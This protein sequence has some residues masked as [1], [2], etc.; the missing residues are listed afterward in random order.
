M[1]LFL[2]VFLFTP[3][4]AIAD[5]AIEKEIQQ[6]ALLPGDAEFLAAREALRTG[7][8]AQLDQAAAHLKQ[9]PL[10]PYVAYYQMLLRLEN[11]DTGT[12]RAFLARPDETPAIDQLRGEWLKILGKRGQ[13]SLFSEE[14][15]QL[16]SEDTE[17]SCYAMQ[18]RLHAHDN[19]A[20]LDAR[21]LWLV[22][23]E[24]QPENCDDVFSKAITEEVIT[25]TDIESRIQLALEAGNTTLASQLSSKLPAKDAISAATLTSIKNN[26][27]RYLKS[28]R[29]KN[30]SKA[31]LTAA[32]FA[33]QR[34]AK[35]LPQ[36]ALNH[37][38]KISDQFSEDKQR[39]FYSWLGY[40][41][42]LMHDARALEW[43]QMAGDA[44]LTEQQHAWKARAAL[45]AQDWSKLLAAIDNMS[46]Q[47]LQQHGAW[48]YWRAR[49]L[50]E[51]GQKEMA[52]RQFAMLSVEHNYYGLLASEEVTTISAANPMLQSYKPTPEEIDEMEANPAIQRALAMF[53]MGLRTEATREWAWAER[54][55]D[56]RQLLVAAEIARRNEIYDRAINTADQTIYLH[57]FNLRY[58]APYRDELREYIQQFD[59]EEAW[60]YGL[61]RQESRFVKHAKS[62]AGAHGLMQV[63]PATARWLA[64]KLGMKGYRRAMVRK[65][66]TN[67]MLG[68]YYMKTV[69]NKFDNNPVLAS[70][71]Y[72][73]GPARALRWRSDKPL[74][75]AIYIE[76]I[77]FDETRG[78]VRKV[79]SNTMYYA[80]LFGQP[81]RSL[82]ERLGTIPARD[83]DSQ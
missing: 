13:W 5:Q 31:Q 41:A 47:Q 38:E 20:L 16:V 68:T 57:D 42:A 49:A 17:L 6:E 77:P 76:T 45:R 21:K 61:I 56:D 28:L 50:R 73:A 72:N 30:P 51:L 15:P 52:D 1:K 32:M 83:T 27:E 19:E 66:D 8:A 54:K 34:L 44:P 10:E 9:S 2:F 58:L 24:E 82:K 81:P 37:W 4:Y 79:M 46:L 25:R 7:N 29:L 35:S 48:R 74:E 71:A 22:S 69:L 53:R 23:R 11:A 43:Y 75:G 36:Q 12:I 63:M 26:P 80:R 18:A 64:R 62:E 33:L 55:F 65:T 14:F 60:V 67:L 59:L 40:E 3:I 78:Y 39:Y 70:A